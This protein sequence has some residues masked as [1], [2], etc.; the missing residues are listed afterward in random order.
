[1]NPDS[2]DLEITGLLH[3]IGQVSAPAAGVL[4]RARQMLW[5]AVLQEMPPG[6]ETRAQPREHNA[7]Q[8]Q[9]TG[10]QRRP[11]SSHQAQQRRN[12]NPGS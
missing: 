5:A 6:Q 9:Q 8:P 4:E 10:R 1:M 12:A 7:S 2:E 11:N 3:V